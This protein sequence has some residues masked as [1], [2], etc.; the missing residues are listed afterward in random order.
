[1]LYIAILIFLSFMLLVMFDRLLAG[2]FAK[3]KGYRKELSEEETRL[4]NENERLRSDNE[5]LAKAVE[6]TIALYD[7]TKDICRTLEEETIFTIFRTHINRNIAIE[8]FDFLKSE[9]QLP[10]NHNVTVLPLKIH[11]NTIGYLYAKGIIRGE[12]K[13]R[14]NILGQQFLLGYKRALLYKEVQQLT[15]TDGLTQVFNRRYFLERFNE[16]LIRSRNLKLNLSF[17]MVDIDRFKS[18]NDH[19]GHLVGDMLLKE[20][21]KIIKETIRQIDFMGRYGGEELTII[22]AETD[23]EQARFAAERIRQAVELKSIRAYDE[24]LTATISIGIAT[25]PD[26]ANE[27]ANLIDR[28]DQALYVAKHTGRNKVC[29]YKAK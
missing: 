1:M 3:I 20:I 22:L 6:E 21:T 28:S 24:E 27:P 4:N 12:D 14:F 16:E 23:K 13:E 15:I 18:Y 8:E 17:L 2:E 19:Y 9:T 29:V 7:L 25:F 5:K 26:D 10:D 11:K